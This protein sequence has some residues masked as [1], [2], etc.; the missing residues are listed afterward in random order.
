MN[1]LTNLT[2]H[3]P[4]NL[5][6]KTTNNTHINTHH[7]IKNITI[8]LNKTL[9][10]TLNNKHK[11]SQFNNTLIPLNKTLIQITININKQPYYIHTNKTKNQTYITIN[12]NYIN[13]LTQHIFKT[14]THHTKITL[15]IQILN[16]HNPHHII[17]TQFKTITHTLHYTITPNPKINN[18]PNTKNIL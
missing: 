12:N 7:T 18:I 15:H 1:I 2:K 11:I 5:T 10:K 6:I 4:I 13:S 9:Q 17:K 16:K 3:T 8:I 14:L